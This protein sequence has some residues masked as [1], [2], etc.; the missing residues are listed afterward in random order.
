VLLG[1]DMLRLQKRLIMLFKLPRDLLN[2]ILK[3]VNTFCVKKKKQW[4]SSTRATFGTEQQS[5]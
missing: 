4:L 1:V 3:C 2:V 5:N